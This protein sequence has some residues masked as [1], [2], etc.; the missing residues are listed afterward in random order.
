MIILFLVLITVPFSI[1]LQVYYLFPGSLMLLEGQEYTYDMDMTTPIPIDVQVSQSGALSFNGEI[2]EDSHRLALNSP[3]VIEP[4]ALGD[5]IIDL[6]LFGVI[7]F[8][9]VNV[10]VLPKMSVIPCGNT[11][12]VKLYTDGILIIGT[13]EIKS[14]DGKSYTPWR[15]ANIYEGDYIE[16]INNIK[17]EDAQHLLDIVAASEGRNLD[18]GIRRNGKLL[19]TTIT[20]IKSSQDHQYKLGLWVRDSTAGIGTLTFYDPDTRNFGALGHGITDIDTGE[21]LTVRQGEILSSSILSVRKGVKGSPGELK[22]IFTQ[23]DASIGQIKKNSPCGIFGRLSQ[24]ARHNYAN[25]TMPIALRSQVREGKAYILSNVQG[26]EIEEYEIEIQKVMRQND[27]SSKGMIIKI[28]DPAL[29]AITGGI[30]QGMSGSPIIQD[31]R[32]VG[33]VTHVFINDPTRGY[34][35]FIDWM[36]KNAIEIDR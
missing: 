19:N 12:G 30:V 35:I 26:E 28:T 21:L 7:P 33:A 16:T 8:R 6:K 25:K 23:Y 11:V 31:G 10:S 13:S 9:S 18:L 5:F 24:E 3:L 4:Q 20:P 22:G 27:E 2:V 1:A 15:D 34:G 17:I 29:V 32:I 36:L 14:V